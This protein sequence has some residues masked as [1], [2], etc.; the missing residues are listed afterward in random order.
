MKIRNALIVVLAM[1]SLSGISLAADRASYEAAM[2]EAQ[3]ANDKS[4]KVGFTWT[5]TENAMKE[6]EKAAKAGDWNKAEAMAKEAKALAEA[7]YAQYEQEK[8]ADLMY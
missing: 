4:S 3:A 6:A 1:F 2:A 5:V 7:S 8:G